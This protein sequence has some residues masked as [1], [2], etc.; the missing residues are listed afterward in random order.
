MRKILATYLTVLLLAYVYANAGGT[1]TYHV[2]RYAEMQVTTAGDTAEV[3]TVT[4]KLTSDS[5]LFKDSVFFTNDTSQHYVA[6]FLAPV[7]IMILT[8]DAGAVDSS[9]DFSIDFAFAGGDTLGFDVNIGDAYVTV[10]KLCDTITSLINATTNLTDTVSA[11]DSGTY[12]KIISLFS[13][14]VL[15]GRWSMIIDTSGGTEGIPDTASRVFDRDEICDTLVALINGDDSAA[16][17]LTAAVVTDTTF[18][19]T[20]NDP[21]VPIHVVSVTGSDTMAA[22][23]TQNNVTSSSQVNDTLIEYPISLTSDDFRALGMNGWIILDHYSLGDTLYGVGISDSASL[24]LRMYR[25]VAGN[26]MYRTLD[27]VL[28]GDI[29]CTLHVARIPALAN[30]T[31]FYEGFYINYYIS[32]TASDV[33]LNRRY[34]IYIDFNLTEM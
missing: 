31:V 8:P 5:G 34:P 28:C 6:S 13:E 25:V 21:G 3:F 4:V 29:P 33:V 30:D 17:Y 22:A 9:T 20:S 27:S 26:K 7:Q 2:T 19:V 16:V 14:E 18:T 1:K 11:E 32:D 23:N 24:W 15:T 12:V 10:A